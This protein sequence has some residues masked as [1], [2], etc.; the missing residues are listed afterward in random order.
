MI[1][2]AVLW[3]YYTSSSGQAYASALSRKTKGG[4]PTIKTKGPSA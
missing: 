2:G 1:N 3:F 4:K